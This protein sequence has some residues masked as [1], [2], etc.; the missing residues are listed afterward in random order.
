MTGLG[1]LLTDQVS[2][3][4]GDRTQ[5]TPSNIVRTQPTP[6][7]TVVLPSGI[8]EH[9]E[10]CVDNYHRGITEKADTFINLQAIIGQHA[11]NDQADFV[12]Q[13]L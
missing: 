12:I 3:P 4:I 13:A 7:I 8:S 5:P 2:H 9:C 10:K 1:D 6:N 11:T